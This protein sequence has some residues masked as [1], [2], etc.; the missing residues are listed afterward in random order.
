M[1]VHNKNLKANALSVA[2][3]SALVAMFAMP[4]LG[5][6]AEPTD[7][8]V[9]FI[10]KP[11][12]FIEVGAMHVSRD[13]A[14]FG[15]YNGLNDSGTEFVG[16]FSVR[17]GDA[18]Q[19]GDGT[20]RWGVTGNDIG[21]TSRELGATIENQGKWNLNIGYDELRHNI[22]DTYQTPLRGGM[23]DNVFTLPSN[24][25][26]IN[27]A[28][29]SARSLTPTQLGAF[30]SEDVSSTRK[31]TSFGAGFQFSPQVSLKFDYNHLDQS[32]AKLIA[33]SSLGGQAI[34]GTTWRAEGVSILM[35][36]TDY[37]T[38]T[39]NL[40]LDW[41]GDSAFL[42]AS[43]F[44][45]IFKDG[46]NSLSW[47]NPMTT[48]A[49]DGTYVAGTFQTNTMSTAPDN[50]LHQLNL[51]GGYTF[52]P[53]TKLVG[54]IS[55]GRNTQDQSFLTGLPE[56]VSTP[57]A[58]LNGE[59]ITKHYNLKLT[60]QT[61]RDLV[62]SAA[63]KYNERD[64]RTSSKIYQYW[65]INSIAASAT[66]KLDYTANAPYSNDRTDFELAGD[67]R[68]DKKQTIRLAYNYEKINRSCD[69][70]VR[71]NA[72][73][74]NCL[75]DTSNTEDKFG[76]KYKL[77]ASDGVTLNAGYTYGN[78]KGSY[79]H[80]AITPLAGL[81]TATP[82][83]VNA[84]NVVGFIAAPYAER[85]QDLFKA[86]VNWQATEQ[87]DLSA[88]G[89]YAKDR[90]NS[91]LGL[92]SGK[93]TGINLDATFSYSED[94]SVSAYVGWQNNKRD[95]KNS[96][97]GATAAASYAL[98]AAGAA[99]TQIWSTELDEDGTFFGISTKHRLLGGKLELIGDLSYTLDKSSYSTSQNYNLTGATGCTT[100]ASLTCVG[101][102]DIKSDLLTLKITGIYD[103]DKSSK[104]S[105]GYLYQKLKADDY[106]YNAYQYGYTPNRVIPTN[107][108]EPDHSVSLFA[109]SYIYNFK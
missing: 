12:N 51:S 78:R 92:Q 7:A 65:A 39:Y 37:K 81:E 5:F 71:S 46:N 11:T 24:F 70:Y 74:D 85:K 14:K 31:N 108:E 22:T 94:A 49:V 95:L 66:N 44:A 26:P 1:K 63:Y 15:E 104:V 102:P 90:Y 105:V 6:A 93:T 100:A 68:I 3:Q 67:Y 33:G 98:L 19:G 61:T 109:V 29:P 8:D 82:T 86:G 40:A 88:T 53:T 18:Y 97:N 30:H 103:L 79:D 52:S 45:S 25:A 20:M 21:T 41:K 96:A 60:N 55:Y 13:S 72:F 57:G 4:V 34:A 101:L 59:V 43:Y 64:N 73:S 23:G 47:Q 56:I 107:Q 42:N 91:D 87:L 16:N 27:G 54:G 35:N 48:A 58:D 76:A 77:K 83:D 80:N 89:R 32:G 62:L 84:Q 75:V 38:D 10:R 69:S 50:Q 9:A 36:P 106:F 28:T 17:G 99:P 2:V